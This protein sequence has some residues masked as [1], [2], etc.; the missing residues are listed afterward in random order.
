[1]NCQEFEAH[2]I[3]L[4]REQLMDARARRAALAHAESCARCAVRISDERALTAG[5]KRMAASGDVEEAPASVEALLLDAFRASRTSSLAPIRPAGARRRQALLWAAAAAALVVIAVIAALQLN[6]GEASVGQQ[7]TQSEESAPTPAAP[8]APLLS[9]Q[10]KGAE[11][12]QAA[13]T[14]KESRP[15]RQAERKRGPRNRLARQADVPASHEATEIAT[16][17]MPLTGG[18]SLVQPDSGQI[19]RVELPRSALLSFGLPMNME[20]ADERIKADL[21]VGNDGLARAIRFVR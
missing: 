19:V 21:I 6:R 9:Q 11:K 2:T 1:M 3:D 5:L 7:A 14:V 8:V 4:A 15:A 20:R 18:G 12:E 16:E 13:D 17:F 10:N